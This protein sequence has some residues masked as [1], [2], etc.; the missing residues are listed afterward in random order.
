MNVIVESR[1]NDQTLLDCEDCGWR[2]QVADCI[3]TY[4]VYRAKRGD[5]DVEPV[6]TCPKCGSK[7]LIERRRG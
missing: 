1:D 5:A 3:H 4:Q 2:G 7:N 6:D